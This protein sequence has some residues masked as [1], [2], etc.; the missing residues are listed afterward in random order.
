[1]VVITIAR[2]TD[3]V[4]LGPDGKPLRTGP[5][6]WFRVWIAPSEKA[7]NLMVA[8]ATEEAAG[9]SERQ[10]PVAVEAAEAAARGAALT[11][12]IPEAASPP[13]T[14]ELLRITLPFGVLR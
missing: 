14:R 12:V 5:E 2:T 9:P 7:T 4:L 8:D 3:P 13:P 1:M 11:V 10:T 6:A